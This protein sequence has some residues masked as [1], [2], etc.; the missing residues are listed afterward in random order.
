VE[1]IV[2]D[3]MTKNEIDP[4][5][6]SYA[7]WIRETRLQKGLTVSALARGAGISHVAIL[8]IESGQIKNP[9]PETWEKI[10]ATLKQAPSRAIVEKAE[11]D[12]IIEGLGYL[13]DFDPYDLET[14]P[15]S[16]GVYV[17]YDISE[18]PIYVGQSVNLRKR[19]R[20]HVDRFWFKPP[21]VYSGSFINVLD[22]TLRNQIERLLIK[23]LRSNAVLNQM[24]VE[25]SG[26]K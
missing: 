17:F 1:E 8:K 15:L 23:F 5:A 22:E 12:S 21:I 10:E 11:R 20:S 9:R 24:H 14:V 25:R 6:S 26:D 2:T 13:E 7:V 4:S 19:I 3:L 18:R 16:A